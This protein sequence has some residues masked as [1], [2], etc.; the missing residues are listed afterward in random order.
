[1][2]YVL[3]SKSECLAPGE[4]F[5]EDNFPSARCNREVF[6]AMEDPLRR[7]AQQPPSDFTDKPPGY[8]GNPPVNSDRGE[9]SDPRVVRCAGGHRGRWRAARPSTGRAAMMRGDPDKAGYRPVA[10][11][12]ASARLVAVSK[13]SLRRPDS[14]CSWMGA[15]L[16]GPM[17]QAGSNRLRAPRAR[18]AVIRARSYSKSARSSRRTASR[19]TK[20]AQSK[21]RKL[22]IVDHGV[23]CEPLPFRSRV[24]RTSPAEVTTNRIPVITCGNGHQGLGI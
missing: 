21:Q 23:G 4:A 17:S 3:S 8:P 16:N 6:E 2:F 18:K 10:A 13:A 22:P 14:D 24:T 15:G 7:P 20:G 1:M 19:L 11:A 12:V 5:A 9:L